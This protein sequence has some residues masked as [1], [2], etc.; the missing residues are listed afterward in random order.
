MGSW[1]LW[2][3]KY[4][5]LLKP[6]CGDFHWRCYNWFVYT[7]THTHTNAAYFSLIKAMPYYFHRLL[8]RLLLWKSKHNYLF[9]ILCFFICWQREIRSCEFSHHKA[10]VKM[11]DEGRSF[12]VWN[13]SW[14]AGSSSLQLH[15][16][17]GII[18]SAFI[19]IRC[20]ALRDYSLFWGFHIG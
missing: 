18:I 11:S 15:F 2:T 10:R 19:K 14:E 7:R 1:Q 4:I 5:Q 6:L 12:Q 3:S 8:P 16:P 17:I 20:L 9:D 13:P